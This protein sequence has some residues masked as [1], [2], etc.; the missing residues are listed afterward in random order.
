MTSGSSGL[1]TR[2]W[3]GGTRPYGFA[4]SPTWPG[5]MCAPSHQGARGG[6]GGALGKRPRGGPWEFPWAGPAGEMRLDWHR[7][8]GP[9]G[10]GPGVVPGS[11]R[12]RGQL[13]R[14][15]WTSPQEGRGLPEA[16]AG[17]RT[18]GSDWSSGGAGRWTRVP[19]VVGSAAF[20]QLAAAS[21]LRFR[22]RHVVLQLL[23][24]RGFPESL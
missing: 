22:W 5:P 10:S 19:A 4:P 23:R 21:A 24:G 1:S 7:G 3:T 15:Y 17:I 20:G 6:R 11:Q 18:P 12:G 16:E 8:A 14:S 2:D 9:W 13:G